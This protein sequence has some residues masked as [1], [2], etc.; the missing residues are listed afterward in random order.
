MRPQ[1][2]L[3]LCE[4]Q[5]DECLALRAGFA[6]EPR[7][8]VHELDGYTGLRAMLPPPEKRALVLIDPPYEA[9]DEWARLA[10]GL[11]DALRRF[12]SGVYAVWYPL[13]E[14][15]RLDAF[16]DELLALR[17]PPTLVAEL[18][19][20]GEG[21]GLRMRG[22]G[23]VIIN[24]PWQFEADAKPVLDWL[25]VKLAQGAGARASLRWLVPE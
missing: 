11:D 14:R 16:A 2:R 9:Q 25:A 8:A 4:L 6:D 10:K 1:E 7:T 5:E 21:A 12:P 24:P 13:T 18:E 19:I 22:S 3:A 17:P 23:L 15:A 20:A